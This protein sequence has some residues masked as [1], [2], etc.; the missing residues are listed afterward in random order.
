[1]KASIIVN[2]S[3]GSL[4]SGK[5]GLSVFNTFNRE[6]L[7]DIDYVIFEPN[8]YDQEYYPELVSLRREMLSFTP[9]LFIQLEW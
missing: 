3:N 5:I 8:L 9:N 1:M 6:N 2:S 7:L 4:G